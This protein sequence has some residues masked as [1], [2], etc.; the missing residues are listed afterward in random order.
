MLPPCSESA[1][2]VFAYIPAALVS[3]VALLGFSFQAAAYPGKGPVQNLIDHVQAPYTTTFATNGMLF[4][5]SV[6]P[7]KMSARGLLD[8]HSRSEA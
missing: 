6:F 5:S 2:V 4:H 7:A 1:T 8:F 3:Q